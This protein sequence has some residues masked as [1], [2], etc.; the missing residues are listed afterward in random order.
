MQLKNVPAYI[1]TVFGLNKD[2]DTSFNLL[3][4]IANYLVPRYKLYWHNIDL[5]SNSAFFNYLK[6]YNEDR[7]LNTQRRWMLLELQR[8]TSSVEG[9]TAECGVYMG[10]SSEGILMQSRE[11]MHYI[12]DSFEG[13]STPKSEDGSYWR[14]GDLTAAQAIVE[15]N[16]ANYNNKKLIKAWIPDGFK[17]VEDKRFSF[18]HIDVDLYQPTLD[19]VKFFYDRL[20]VGGVLVCDDYGFSSC[21]GATKA[22]DEFLKDKDEKMISLPCGGGFFIKG[23]K[24]QDRLFDKKMES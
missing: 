17:A 13:L 24:S 5:L 18:V 11:K 16:L 12:F 8:L 20:N 2:S 6:K 4:K 3:I 7:S 1:K 15:K 14:E 22:I 23:T 19:S 10:C 9:D 21:I